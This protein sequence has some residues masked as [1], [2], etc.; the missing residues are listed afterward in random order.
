M[1]KEISKEITKLEERA[2]KLYN[3]KKYT[4]LELVEKRL[5][6]LRQERIRLKMT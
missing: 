5:Y 2:D 6:E 3:K 1:F 4:E